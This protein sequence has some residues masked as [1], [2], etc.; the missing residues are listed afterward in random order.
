MPPLHRGE[1][2]PLLYVEAADSVPIQIQ[3]RE[4]LLYTEERVS[5]CYIYIYTQR[6][7][8][9]HLLYVEEADSFSRQRRECLL[10]IEERVPL[11]L[12]VEEADS[13]SRQ[14]RVVSSLR[15]EC[16]LHI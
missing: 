8:G 16:L 9:P 12:Y 3:R 14:R 10:Y 4:R 15:R 5:L 2:A 13:F 11:L 6:R 7:E 1:S